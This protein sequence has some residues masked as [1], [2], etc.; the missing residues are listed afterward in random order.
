[1]HRRVTFLV[2]SLLFCCVQSTFA[3]YF[4]FQSTATS[5]QSST[6]NQWSQDRLLGDHY[7][8]FLG[9]LRYEEVPGHFFRVQ[10]NT[11]GISMQS[12]GDFS[13]LAVPEAVGQDEHYEFVLNSP[14]PNYLSDKMKM[15][16]SYKYQFKVRVDFH[17]TLKKPWQSTVDGNYFVVHQNWQKGTPPFSININSSGMWCMKVRDGRN[18]TNTVTVVPLVTANSGVWYTFDIEYMAVAYPNFGIAKATV[19]A[20]GQFATTNITNQ[21][22]AYSDGLQGPIPKF[23]MYLDKD[24]RADMEA[25]VAVFIRGV[26]FGT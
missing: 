14:H 13:M 4:W 10:P 15:N 24:A 11:R 19:N 12:N 20:P 9:N 17:P 5:G 3:Q 1:M 6:F 18:S 7:K 26:K 8:T 21:G 16:T 25:P 23:G 2:L 22:T